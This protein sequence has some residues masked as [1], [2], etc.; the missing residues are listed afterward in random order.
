[1]FS[2][3]KMSE[4]QATTTLVDD[5]TAFLFLIDSEML[6]KLKEELPVKDISHDV[7]KLAWWKR[8][9]SQLP[10]LAATL[11]KTILLV[12]NSSAAVERVFRCYRT[13]MQPSRLY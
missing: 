3:V 8:H 9:E 7:D 6:E 1:M 12:Q 2:P 10:Y 11:C 13:A 4:L 5:L